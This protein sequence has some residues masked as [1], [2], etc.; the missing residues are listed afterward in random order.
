MIDE[1]E[2]REAAA[3]RSK[4]VAARADRPKQRRCAEAATSR[5]VMRA[6]AKVEIRAASSS[7]ELGFTGLAS[8]YESPYVMYDF[9]G[10]YTEIVSQGA[11]AQ[12]LANP[13]LDVPLVLQHDSLRRIAS[14]TIPAGEVGALSLS[15]TGEGLQVDAPKLDAGDAD[16][17]Y[18][19]PKLQSGLINEMSFMFMITSGQWSPDYEEFRINSYDIDRGDVSI[20]G[21]GANP[22]TTAA[23]RSVMDKLKTGRALEQGDVQ[24]IAD[25]LDWLAG[26][27]QVVDEARR[28]LDT[29]KPDAGDA[30]MQQLA[31]LS[32]EALRRAE[33]GIRYELRRRKLEPA[34]TL[35]DLIELDI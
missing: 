27:D 17:S 19:V 14:T 34:R 6:K 9:F 35:H 30:D 13:D 11:G 20:V 33:R 18:I 7:S 21:Y 28:A 26:V 22:A 23:L 32:L 15:E 2:L 29:I 24:L 31:E 25:G 5:G 8:A 3:A 12:S 4:A 1:D 16:V 10:P